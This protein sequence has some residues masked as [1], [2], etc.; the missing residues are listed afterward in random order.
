ML[1]MVDPSLSLIKANA[2]L[3]CSLIVLAQPPTVIVLSIHFVA[4]SDTK[5]VILI[6]P[7][8]LKLKKFIN[9]CK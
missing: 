4:S 6:R 5:E 2:P 7:P 8:Y 1:F 3:P 9:E